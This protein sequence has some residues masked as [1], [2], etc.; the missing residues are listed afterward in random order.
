MGRL[1]RVQIFRDSCIWI[2]W[3]D[4]IKWIIAKYLTTLRIATERDCRR[5]YFV[6]CINFHFTSIDHLYLFI[7]LNSNAFE[8]FPCESK[9]CQGIDANPTKINNEFLAFNKSVSVFEWP[10]H[11]VMKILCI[12]IIST[13]YDTTMTIRRSMKTH[14]I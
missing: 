9:Q 8:S 14:I 11:F 5:L 4:N 7:W 2:R 6:W 10:S 13:T 12:K 1:N 3:C